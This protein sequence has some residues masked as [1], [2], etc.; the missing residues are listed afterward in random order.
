MP[1]RLEHDLT[2]IGLDE[3]EAK[4]YL[5]V[6]E[7]GPSPV[8]NIA[9]RSGIPRATTY[10]VL[11]EL[12]RKGLVTTFEKGKKTLFAAESP[13]NL[14]YLLA[15]KSEAIRDQERLLKA[16]IPDLKSRG[17]F[18]GTTR[19]SV[20]FYEGADA[21]R[22]L[23]RDN[24]RPGTKETLGIFSHDDAER[25]L[26]KAGLYWS[27]LVKRRSRGGIRRRIIY[28]WRHAKPPPG[29][30]REG[31]AY[32]PYSEF[33]CAADITI[34]GNRVAFVPYDEPTRAVAIEDTSIANA[35]R[36]VFD[37]LWK[38]ARRRTKSA[39]KTGH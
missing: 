20:R 34:V 16:L 37:A 23:I 27:D 36:S 6:L 7:L 21:L 32:I 17:Q 29:T 4:V 26:Q 33:P 39:S 5:A 19:P 11:D 35:L 25:L 24:L 38:R 12:K 3:K 28:T 8:Q 2:Q 10:L 1:G 22:A 31:A 14:T 13:E 30:H 15:E 9:Q 18:A